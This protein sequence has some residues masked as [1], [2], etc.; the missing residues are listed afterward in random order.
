MRPSG[1]SRPARGSHRACSPITSG[2]KEQLLAATYRHLSDQFAEAGA[3][4]VEAAGAEAADRLRAF[5]A[6]GFRRAVPRS[7][8][9]AAR[10]A[11]WSIAATGPALHSVHV[12]LYRRYRTELAGLIAPL[13]P[14]GRASDRLVFAVSALLDG[15][16]L[17]R[18][19]R[20]A[21]RR[22]RG[23]DRHLP[24][25]DPSRRRGELVLRSVAVVAARHAPA[26]ASGPLTA[27]NKSLLFRRSGEGVKVFF[28]DRTL[29]HDTG[30]GMWE[31]P[32]S[33]LLA[34]RRSSTRKMPC[35]SATCAPCS[36]TG[37][38]SEHLSWAGGRLAE[39]SELTTVHDPDY[40]AAV[41]SLCEEGG[42]RLT[43]TTV[44]S[45][46]S[47][48]PLLAAAGTS[49]AAADAVLDGTTPLA[50]ALVRPPGHHA[51]PAQADGFC[52]FSH[53]ALVAQARP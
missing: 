15:L 5:L 12:E 22:R 13:M 32:P 38:V 37:P 29:E 11:L 2:Q 39:V 53:A 7:R 48:E 4:A 33:Q 16:W 8:H 6:A 9:L 28:D 14:D 3:R 10:V 44:V 51:Q 52:V 25:A 34:E 26:G 47:W 46:R 50:F 40:V 43:A 49:L 41:R 20:R 42:G 23:D 27:A 31:D 36:S 17:E 18:A 19:A 21:R 45:G 24:R 1:S 30:S 35:G